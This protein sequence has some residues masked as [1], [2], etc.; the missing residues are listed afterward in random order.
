MDLRICRLIN[1]PVDRMD[2]PASRLEQPGT[3]PK[4]IIQIIERDVFHN[5]DG[6]NIIE[7]LV[8]QVGVE[9]TDVILHDPNLREERFRPRIISLCLEFVHQP[10]FVCIPQEA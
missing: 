6:K 8:W 9:L 1:I 3:I 7:I 4:E 10:A 2:H 5:R